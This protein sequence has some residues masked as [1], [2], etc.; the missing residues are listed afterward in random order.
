[1]SLPQK[2]QKLLQEECLNPS[3]L[4][5]HFNELNSRHL[6]YSDDFQNLLALSLLSK[7]YRKENRYQE[8]DELD[9][10]EA[11]INEQIANKLGLT[12]FAS[13]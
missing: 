8:L 13:Y 3:D 2:L 7:K 5:N 12:S 9:I 4:Q 1:M 11:E 10:S 6:S